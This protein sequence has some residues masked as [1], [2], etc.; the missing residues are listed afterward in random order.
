MSYVTS[1]AV[2]VT[3]AYDALFGALQLTSG[4][5]HLHSHDL[6][7]LFDAAY[8]AL[9][10]SHAPKYLRDMQ[11]D[12]D[13][14]LTRAHAQPRHLL[15]M[16]GALVLMRDFDAARAL[17]QRYPQVPFE[18][19]PT[20]TTLSRRCH[21]ATPNVFAW[22]PSTQSLRCRPALYEAAACILVLAAPSCAMSQAALRL[23][24]QD[25]VLHAVFKTHA[26]WLIPPRSTLDLEAMVHWNSAH[27]Q[28]AL[29]LM[30]HASD[31]PIASPFKTP[32][33]CFR[34]ANGMTRIVTAMPL[35][36][37][38]LALHREIVA[39]HLPSG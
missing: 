21:P 14:L 11:Q 34:R 22:E 18:A 35:P 29:V 28:A 31:W 6:G 24:E 19:I 1:R 20:I 7:L 15:E 36:A 32:T 13:E 38:G 16:H 3:H 12:L 17:R 30:H 10:Y 9:L 39:A 26:A 2:R 25:P 37:L 33:F 4:L 23:I 8:T 27:P 5:Q